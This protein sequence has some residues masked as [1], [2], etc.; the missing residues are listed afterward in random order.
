M[1]AT[2]VIR[3]LVPVV[4]SLTITTTCLSLPFK[5]VLVAMD[6]M[7]VLESPAATMDIDRTIIIM[8]E[9]QSLQLEMEENV[10]HLLLK[11]MSLLKIYVTIRRG[12]LK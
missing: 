8:I 12:L 10:H 5:E 1:S 4:S 6:I 2:H 9:D 11:A 7:A 3:E